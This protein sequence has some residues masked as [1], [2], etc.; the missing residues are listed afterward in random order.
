MVFRILK[1][2]LNKAIKNAGRWPF[3]NFQLFPEGLF[4]DFLQFPV[5]DLV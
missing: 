1:T 5:Y 4:I 3:S 2:W